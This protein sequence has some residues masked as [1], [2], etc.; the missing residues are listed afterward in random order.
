MCNAGRDP[1]HLD[2]RGATRYAPNMADRDH[3]LR[4]IDTFCAEHD[5]T[6]AKFGVLAVN[7]WR[8]VNDLRGVNRARPRRVWPETEDVI[9]SFMKAYIG[10]G[11][12][13]PHTVSE[14]SRITG[15]GRRAA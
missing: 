10:R 4:D 6:P 15:N 8:F 7:D 11:K 14:V 5:L 9:R 2:L 13:Q 1:E 3:L 12:D